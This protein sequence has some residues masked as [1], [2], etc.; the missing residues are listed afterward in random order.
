[1]R[2]TS[3]A[4]REAILRAMGFD[5]STEERA[6]EASLALD[7]E[8]AE[9][10]LD[11]VR[12][13]V[14]KGRMTRTV[15]VRLPE[16]LREGSVAWSVE[17]LE[18]SG[19]RRRREGKATIRGTSLR[20][21]VPVPAE[22]GYHVLRVVLSR[23]GC[24]VRG[25]QSVIVCPAACPA[26]STRLGKRS[27]FGLIA[28][29]YTARSD[30]NWGIGDLTDLGELL[31]WCREVGGAFV[32]INP[33]HAIRN[34]GPEVSPYSP[35]SRLFLNPLYLDVEA[36][37]EFAQR[38]TKGASPPSTPS[39]AT[40]ARLR[41]A[42]RIDYEA[43]RESKLA[44]LRNLHRV[45][46]RRHGEGR[47]GRGRAYRRFREEAGPALDAFATFLALDA[48]HSRP[49][50]SDSDGCRHW[51]LP[52]RDPLS[53]DVSTF[54]EE[55]AEEIDFHRYLQ[56]ETDRQLAEAVR[57]GRAG[58]L[59]IGLYQDLPVGTR[60]DGFDPW[61]FPRLFVDATTIGAP[62]DQFNPKG[63]VWGL[64]PLDPRRLVEDRY[65]YWIALLRRA[66]RHSGALRIDH[67]M[68]LRRL[69]WVHRDLTAS[70]GAYVRYPEDDLL[71]ILA[72][73]AQRHRALVVGEDL[74]TVPP[75]LRSRLARRRIL[76]S[77]VFYF[78]RTA[79]GGFRR[80]SSYPR[81]A[82]ATADTHDLPTL[83]G[84]WN[85]LDL[86]DR[87]RLGVFD[88]DEALD[89]ARARRK[90][91][92]EEM[93]RVVAR[94][95]GRGGKKTLDPDRPDSDRAFV[96]AVH[97]FLARTPCRL[98]GL[99]LD[100]LAGEEE[101]V[102]LPGVTQDRHPSW[103]RRMGPTIGDLRSDPQVRAEISVVRKRRAGR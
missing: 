101:P 37:P 59:S 78:E 93:V 100:D 66:L 80:A 50:G 51:P 17:L 96:R 72:L 79:R 94:D 81:L 61:G 3:D 22:T 56:F 30:R 85:G 26:P 74:G 45:F 77:K 16:S 35:I 43:I 62:P 15:P 9:R 67:V 87:R 57:H 102:N 64:A 13:L 95:A 27:A 40:L 65:R 44:V 92:R 54:R 14:R 89:A 97:A 41:G 84:F 52:F 24:E 90:R 19:S 38:E 63:Q 70:E 71:G 29:L 68:G 98:V 31:D 1:V 82:L 53:A 7:R 4:T 23:G 39:E 42:A 86:D 60:P 11:P 18:E 25:E 34:A 69:Y 46:S 91:D 58:A 20:L 21:P 103:T 33:L 75:G 32:G 12:V 8:E 10:P 55:H 28:N 88:S 5:A 2:T 6:A 48:R 99:S 49:P 76:S 36:V 47:T 73:E 83:R